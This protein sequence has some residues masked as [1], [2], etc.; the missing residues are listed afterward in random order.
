MKP[1][2]GRVNQMPASGQST[3]GPPAPASGNFAR[4]RNG[5]PFALVGFVFGLLTFITAKKR[6]Q[7]S[8]VT[9]RAQLRGLANTLQAVTVGFELKRAPL[10]NVESGSRRSLH[11]MENLSAQGDSRSMWPVRW[12]GTINAPP[13]QS[14]P[15]ASDHVFREA[16]EGKPP[17]EESQWAEPETQPASRRQLAPD[18]VCASQNSQTEYPASAPSI[19]PPKLPE[20]YWES[21]PDN[22]THLQNAGSEKTAAEEIPSD[23]ASRMERLRGLFAEAGLEVLHRNRGVLPQSEQRT[24]TLR[25]SLQSVIS[26]SSHAAA[27]PENLSPR[28]FVP[29]KLPESTSGDVTSANLDDEIRILPSKRG[30]Y[31]SR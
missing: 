17:S 31:G 28:E 13:R 11:Y 27:T 20:W 5:W 1:L 12:H 8:G 29:I 2:R 25:E 21:G 23:T 14:A 7:L 10:P 4:F 3:S 15:N 24:S 6:F 9:I 30:Q 19:R 26:A 18:L 16:D 22:F